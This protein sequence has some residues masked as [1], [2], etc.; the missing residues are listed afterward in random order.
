IRDGMNLVAKEG[1]LVNRRDG[2]IVLSHEAGAW[3]E[4]G[5]HVVGVNPYDITG[6][7]RAIGEALDLDSAERRRRAEAVRRA[8][9]SRGPREWLEDQLRAA[10]PL[11]AS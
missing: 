5:D 7:A 6:T 10:G 9:E 1:P 4:L 3:G 8:V 2:A 11:P